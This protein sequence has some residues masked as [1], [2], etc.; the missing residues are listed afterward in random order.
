MVPSSLSKHKKVAKMP[1]IE[2]N[3]LSKLWNFTPSEQFVC[4]FDLL[5][6][7][8]KV[9]SQVERDE[10]ILKVLRTLDSDLVTVGAH[11]AGDWEKG[12]GENFE[13]YKQSKNLDDVI[14][15]YFNKIPLV[16]WKQ[17]WV[18]PV[19]PTLEYDLLGLIVEYITET[20]LLDKETIY[21]FG[22]GTG[23]NLLRIRNRI[24]HSK[25]VGLD[26]ASS[27]QKLIKEIA[28]STSDQNLFAENFNYFEP[29]SELIIEEGSAVLTVASLEQTGS[30]FKD[31]IEFIALQKPSVVIHIEPMWEPLDAGNLLDYLSIKYFEK[32][33]YLNG[34]QRYVEDLEKN[35]RAKIIN[36][37]RTGIGSFFI[38]GYSILVWKPTES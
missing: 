34:L 5:N 1:R 37:Q 22:C 31:F 32:R 29:N 13:N 15:K 4:D 30:E 21:E 19:N 18:E 20:Y 6:L 3:E 25:L 33:K 12:W 14:P 27:S 16:R 10:A 7:D 35:G 38:D 2:L 24:P 8:F 11:R 36:K 23:H 28:R 9:L 26:W 17:E